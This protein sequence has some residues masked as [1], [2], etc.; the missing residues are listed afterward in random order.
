MENFETLDQFESK[1]ETVSNN[2]SSVKIIGIYFSAHWC[3]PCK[4]FTPV[5]SKLYE[6]V[7]E[8]GKVFEVVFVSLDKDEKTYRS[9]LSTMP[10]VALPFEHD[11]CDDL[12][13]KYKVSGIPRLVIL[14]PDGE[15]IED[16]ARTAV[17]NQGVEA[18]NNW[19]NIS[20]T[21]TSNFSEGEVVSVT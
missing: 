2:L 11:L 17:T 14:H 20:Q 10:W 21:S 5:L 13:L 8:N 16:N 6:K 18:F 19:T 3:P 1:N 4:G 9:Y 15:V 12:R 7:N